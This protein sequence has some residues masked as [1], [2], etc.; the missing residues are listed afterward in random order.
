MATRRKGRVRQPGHI[1]R[2]SISL[3]HDVDAKIQQLAIKQKRSAN[4]VMEGLI[5]AGLQAREEEK[6]RFLAT[7]ERFRTSADAA[8]IERTKNELARM[9]FGE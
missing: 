3:P 6:R 4:R 5:E 9:I 2:R 8:E 1:V 7:A